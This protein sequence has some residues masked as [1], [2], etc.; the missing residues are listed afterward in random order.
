M[1]QQLKQN[2]QEATYK[3]TGDFSLVWWFA[4]PVILTIA[5][6]IWFLNWTN[7]NKGEGGSL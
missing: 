2:K 6:I 7:S 4:I 5:G 1:F 3:M